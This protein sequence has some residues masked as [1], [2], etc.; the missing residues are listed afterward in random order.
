MSEFPNVMF[1]FF[2]IMIMNDIVSVKEAATRGFGLALLP[3]YMIADELKNNE[4]KAVLPD[5]IAKGRP[6]HL[7][8]PG[9]KFVSPKMREF[10]DHV[11]KNFSC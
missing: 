5:W 7:V 9:Q 2:L 3:N 4:L 1:L 6:I 11:T 8:F 10:I